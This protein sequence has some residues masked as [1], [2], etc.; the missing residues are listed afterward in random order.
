MKSEGV[1]VVRE[2]VERLCGAGVLLE[3]D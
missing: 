3:A 1:D 2:V